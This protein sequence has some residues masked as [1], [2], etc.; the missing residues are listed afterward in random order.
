MFGWFQPR[1]PLRTQEK[2]W[3]E[4][5]MS[6]LAAKLGA[7]RMLTAQMI[8]PTDEFF[9]DEYRASVESAQRMF[10]RLLDYMRIDPDRVQLVVR[11]DW[12]DQDPLGEY[13]R[14]N[15]SAIHIN[16]SQYADPESLV[17]TL[18][19]ELAHEIL[20]GGG[21]VEG[22]DEDLER[23][24]DLLP[25]FLGLGIFCANSAFR[26]RTM[27]EGRFSWWSIHKQ[28]YLPMRMH[29]YGL[30]VFAYA[31]EETA[32]SW[33]DHLRL[34]IHEP[35]LKG[36][37]YLEKTG[38]T[39]LDLTGKT[40]S[41]EP[42]PID[43]CV[44]LLTH[45]SP[46]H[47]LLALSCLAEHGPGAAPTVE[48]VA[49]LLHDGD[50]DIPVAAAH[51]LGEIG[52]AASSFVPDLQLMLTSRNDEH[53]MQAASALGSLGLNNPEVRDDLLRALEDSDREVSGT[54]AHSLGRCAPGDEKVARRL[55]AAYE[56]ALVK[57]DY[58]RIAQI[59][60]AL[61]AT[62]SDPPGLV[63]E[64]FEPLGLDLLLLAEDCLA[65]QFAP[66]EPAGE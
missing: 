35:M 12:T 56:S 25:A 18:T 23:L 3:V 17:G 43:E 57:C 1:C 37:R 28:G 34:D 58:W 66:T 44:K 6:W 27:R 63:R 11:E 46:S 36:L 5:R 30:A 9:P 64:H 65:E 13:V 48:L 24:T 54:A 55:V 10:D 49:N 29:A 40:T 21:L 14:G 45:K 38:D 47:R 33:A 22:N 15:P 8:E 32:P 31:R 41:D 39:T 50:A 52:P 61:R 20:L 4:T 62:A 16:P 26:E 53:R 60:E 51:A 59:V 7:A 19:H 42:R 2:V